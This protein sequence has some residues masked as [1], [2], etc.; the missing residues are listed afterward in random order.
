MRR[1]FVPSL[2]FNRNSL[3]CSQVTILCAVPA[4]CYMRSMSG[5]SLYGL[6]VPSLWHV[7]KMM[8]YYPVTFLDRHRHLFMLFLTGYGKHVCQSELKLCATEFQD[9]QFTFSNG[10]STSLSKNLRCLGR[11]W[12]HALMNTFYY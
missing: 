3:I 7:V 12:P 9:M 2:E 11:N 6:H 1:T 4:P 5:L 10:I 8:V